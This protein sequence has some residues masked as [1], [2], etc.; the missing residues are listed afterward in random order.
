[1]HW[2]KQLEGAPPSLELPT[3]R[4]RPPIVTFAGAHVPIRL[5]P[6][7]RAA[8]EALSRQEGVTRF[9]TLLAAFQVLLGRYARQDDVIVGTPIANRSRSETE[10]IVG[11]F[12]NMLA[13]RTDLSGEPTFCE[14]LQRV[15]SVTL[16][17]YANQDVP[18]ERVVEAV[19][20]R[21]DLSRS[22]L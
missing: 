11:F 10:G 12:V 14:L 5:S 9:M 20:H 8:V 21:R 13:I 17:A 7:L 19:R 1:T 3:D 18:F 22:P 15:K 16:A 2:T 6:K 4:P